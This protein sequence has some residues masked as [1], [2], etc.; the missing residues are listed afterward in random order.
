MSKSSQAPRDVIQRP[1]CNLT[2]VKQPDVLNIFRG[3]NVK[4]PDVVN[5]FRLCILKPNV[6]DSIFRNE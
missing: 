4:S 5:I 2:Y 6:K 1:V 3:I